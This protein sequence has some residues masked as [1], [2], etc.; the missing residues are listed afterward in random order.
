[1]NLNFLDVSPEI[2]LP[3]FGR[4]E[5]SKY[6]NAALDSLSASQLRKQCIY[7]YIYIYI[8]IFHT[9]ILYFT[10]KIKNNFFG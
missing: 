8:Y 4:K 7:I 3:L 2:V 10:S 1:M 9:L 5:N 6:L